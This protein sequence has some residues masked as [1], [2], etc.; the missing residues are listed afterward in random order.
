MA[1]RRRARTPASSSS[2]ASS[3]CVPLISAAR[4]HTRRSGSASS[5]AASASCTRRRCCTPALCRTAERTSGCRN[6]IELTSRSMSAASTAGSSRVEI[7]RRP[8]DGAGRLEDLAHGVAVAERGDQQDEAGGIGQIGY[9]SG[10]RALEALGQRQAAGHRRLVLGLGGDRRQLEQRQRVAG[11]LTQ[12]AVACGERKVR[13]R[14]V[15]QRRRRRVVEAGK[16]VLRQPRVGERR[17][18]AVTRGGQ[19]DDRVG[20]DS[21]SDEREH[22]RGRGVE[23]VRVLD[24]E[25]QRGIVGDVRDEVERGHRDP[26]V[27]GRR[28]RA[29]ARTRRR[30]PPAGSAAARPHAR[31]PGRSS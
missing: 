19:Q 18:V 23:P 11:G 24:D 7:Q 12:H 31:V 14:C 17:G 15:E 10:E 28:P 6:R 3:S 8:G 30:A 16:P 9:A 2:R 25:Q 1:P 21:P 22:V 20:L 26:E 13:G 5:V 4:C 27:L 29:S